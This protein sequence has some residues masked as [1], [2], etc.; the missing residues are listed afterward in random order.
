[1][2][3]R[4]LLYI[5]VLGFKDMVKSSPSKVSQLYKTID[6]LN[7]HR[8]KVFRTIVF[9]DTILVYNVVEPLNRFDHASLVMYS[10]EYF[11]D[12]LYKTVESNVHFRAVLRYGEFDHYHLQHIE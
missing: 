2:P 9:S 4:Y 12:L 3:E 10:C 11:Q 7:V 5:D 6:S 1:M 8:N